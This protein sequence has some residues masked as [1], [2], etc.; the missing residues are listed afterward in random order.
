VIAHA[1]VFQPGVLFLRSDRRSILKEDG[2]HGT[3][4]FVVE[5]LSPHTARYDIN[6]KREVYARCGLEEVF[7]GLEFSVDEIFRAP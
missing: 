7:P 2:L 3:P 4:D 1:N 6:P 5:I